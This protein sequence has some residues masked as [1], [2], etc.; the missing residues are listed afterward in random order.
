MPQMVRY[1]CLNCG[2]QFQT[3][4]LNKDEVE[5]AKRRFQPLS[6]IHCPVCN[7]TDLRRI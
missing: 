4:V 7:R 3:E 2:N 1:H 5:E 6:S